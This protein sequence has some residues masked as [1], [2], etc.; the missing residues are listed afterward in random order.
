MY[1]SVGT[2]AS[3]PTG[4]FQGSI[5]RQNLKARGRAAP[6]RAV[7]RGTGQGHAG[8]PRIQAP[9]ARG[10]WL[11]LT[12]VFQT[13]GPHPRFA[14][15]PADPLLDAASSRFVSQSQLRTGTESG[16]RCVTLLR[17][18]GGEPIS[19]PPVSVA[20]GSRASFRGL[21]QPRDPRTTNWTQSQISLYTVLFPPLLLL[22][23]T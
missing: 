21:L 4:T 18:P 12:P 13:V 9:H 6:A 3:R 2:L 23:Q 19:D 1:P 11:G 10:P 14:L 16:V 5:M 15:R 7:S 22:R 8:Q 20:S 17:T